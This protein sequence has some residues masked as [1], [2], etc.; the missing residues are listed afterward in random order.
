MVEEGDMM[1][2]NYMTLREK[3][4]LKE[5]AAQWFHDNILW[6][7]FAPNEEVGYPFYLYFA[8]QQASLL[9]LE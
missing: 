2:Y 7:L 6:L 8:F 4:E 5:K 1:A 3:P 9:S